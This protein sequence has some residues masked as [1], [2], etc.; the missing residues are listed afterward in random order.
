MTFG[1]EGFDFSVA[2][3]GADAPTFGDLFAEGRKYVFLVEDTA[4]V[5]KLVQAGLAGMAAKKKAATG[6]R[7]GFIATP[8]PGVKPE[9]PVSTG[10]SVDAQASADARKAEYAADEK[11]HQDARL[12]AAKE[13]AAKPKKS[14][15]KK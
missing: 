14:K 11:A 15:F 3:Q 8:K 12:A 7:E 2:T 5:V 9:R 1:F 13:K 10:N 6:T 4:K